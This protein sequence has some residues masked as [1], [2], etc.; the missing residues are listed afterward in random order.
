[1]VR[2]ELIALAE[3]RTCRDFF[4]HDAGADGVL[5]SHLQLASNASLPN[6][7]RVDYFGRQW[8]RVHHGFGF[9]CVEHEHDRTHRLK[10]TRGR[11]PAF[12]WRR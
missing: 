11:A 2:G 4:H 7:E 6:V 3:P 8:W 9:G 12:T 10:I 1:M 5:N